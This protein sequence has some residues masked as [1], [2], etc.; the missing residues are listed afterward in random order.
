MDLLHTCAEESSVHGLP[1]LV[2]KERHWLERVIWAVIVVISIYCSYAVCLSTWTRYQE[3]PTVL[4]LETDYRHWTYRPP[5]VTIC[6]A[7]IN[8]DGIR[9]VIKKYWNV[10][11]ESDLY[12]FYKQFVTAVANTTYANMNAFLPFVGNMSFAKVNMLEIARTVRNL[13]T[14]PSKNFVPVITETGMC[15]TSSNYSRFQNIGTPPNESTRTWPSSCF[16]YDLCKSN[17]ILSAYGVVKIH[18]FV[19]TEDEVMVATDIIKNEMNQTE[20]VEVTVLVDQIVASSGLKNLSPTRRKCL[21][22]HES[23]LYF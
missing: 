12:P 23:K 8:D 13:D 10:G 16:S 15:F 21:Y 4:T 1:H 18:L 22:D 3:N 7:F 14:M 11:E 2:A 17:V 5:A 6:P 9:E 19:H 20:L